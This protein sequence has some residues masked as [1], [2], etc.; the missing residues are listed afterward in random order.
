GGRDNGI[1]WRAP[2]P[3][4]QQDWVWGPGG[5][6]LAPAPPFQFVKENLSGTNPKVLVRDAR[7]VKWMVKFGGEVHA[8]VFNS[9]L[10][11]A[12]GYN[13]QPT[14]YVGQG[15][16][17]DA[18]DLKRAKAFIGKDGRFRNARFQLRHDARAADYTW[19]W[20]Q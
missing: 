10:L 14:Y 15:A 7:G 4:T 2:R 1:V 19:T 5:E 9:R 13:A 6:Q 20:T 16:I 12:V 17:A 18:K 8:D 11:S 3:M